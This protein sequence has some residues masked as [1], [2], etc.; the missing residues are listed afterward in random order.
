MFQKIKL[1]DWDAGQWF[2]VISVIACVSLWCLSIL[3]AFVAIFIDGPS[4]GNWGG[5]AALCACLALVATFVA[6]IA[7]EE[8]F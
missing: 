5:A 7:A 3:L 2:A 4:E 6:A 8:S 1:P